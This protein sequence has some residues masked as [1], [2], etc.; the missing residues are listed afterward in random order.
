[1]ASEYSQQAE[2]LKKGINN[3]YWDASKGLYAQTSEKKLFSQHAN[4]LAIITGMVTGDQAKQMAQKILTDSTLSQC[5]VY[6]KFYLHEA[7]VKAGLGDDFLN[8]LDIWRE[9]IRMGLTTWGETSDVD[10]TRSDCHAWGAS[11]NIEFFRTLLGID[12]AAPQ[13]AK[14]KIEPR[15][16]DIKQ[17]GGTMPHPQGNIKVNYQKNGNALKAE[18][19]LP[20]GV[21]GTLVWAGKSYDLKGGKNTVDAK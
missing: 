13:F 12:S 1:M 3:A 8:W 9:N 18:I 17:I 7:L 2:H 11:P 5:T 20:A 15:L 6:Y 19:E 21:N 10:G 14:V 4:A 16:G